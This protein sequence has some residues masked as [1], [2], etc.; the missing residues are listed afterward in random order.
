MSWP[1]RYLSTD[2]GQEVVKGGKYQEIRD[3]IVTKGLYEMFESY[4]PAITQLFFR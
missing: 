4:R 2:I 3:R 1:D